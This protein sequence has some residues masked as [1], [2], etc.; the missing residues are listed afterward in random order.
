MSMICDN[1]GKNS[2]CGLYECE[3]CRKN[4]CEKCS[5]DKDFVLCGKCDEEYS[6]GILKKEDM[7]SWLVTCGNC[8]N[9]WDGNA[10]CNCWDFNLDNLESD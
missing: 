6:K 4:V 2:K 1:C 3:S 8:G 7:N 5:Y 9:Q 10:Q